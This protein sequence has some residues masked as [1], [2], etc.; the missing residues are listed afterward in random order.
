M[1]III[2]KFGGSS[3]A[4]PGRIRRA[5]AMVL[6]ERKRG[7]SPVA[8]VSA[9]ADSTDDLLKLA[10]L[11][12][13][14]NPSLR[15]IDA[16][17]ASGE[18]ISAALVALALA[19]EGAAA[20]SLTGSQAGIRT[21]AVF[22]AAAVLSVDAHRLRRELKAGRVPVVAGFQGVSPRGEITTLGRGGSD[23]SAVVIARALKAARCEFRTDVKG[24]YT[25]HPAIVP[26][27][28]KIKAISY[29]EV[30]RLAELGT[31]VR[32]LR[33][34]KYAA[35]HRIPLHLR[36]SFH[37]EPGTMVT[38]S[39]GR[40]GATC[41]S[42]KKEGGCTLV[43]VIGRGLNKTHLAGMLRAAASCGVKADVTDFSSGAATLRTSH[44]EGEVLLKALHGAFFR[45]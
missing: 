28:R 30:I 13:G 10:A 39:G 33:A 24:I 40:R 42:I 43:S 17:L 14:N 37:D 6:R 18:Q 44:A 15:E 4:D 20:I 12:G 11:A 22:S 26:G 31:E 2:I 23:L 9:P 27:A 36:S 3:L 32:Q 7:F 25:A 21:D 38:A 5:A 1:K 19:Y 34:V 45:R 41:L 35:G 16:L 8:V 29:E